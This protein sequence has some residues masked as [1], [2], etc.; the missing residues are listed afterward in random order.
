[1]KTVLVLLILFLAGGYPSS[2]SQDRQD[3]QQYLD[4]Q[5]ETY[6][7][8]RNQVQAQKHKRPSPYGLLFGGDPVL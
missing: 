4:R 3:E 1:M 7:Y 5:E 6:R 2:Y 8:Y